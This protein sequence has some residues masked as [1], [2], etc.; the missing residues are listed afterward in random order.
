[1]WMT[2]N[3]LNKKNSILLLTV[4]IFLVLVVF[5]VVSLNF[6]GFYRLNT[7]DLLIF[8]FF[9]SI[10][11]ILLLVSS[12]ILASLLI[13]VIFNKELFKQ[14]FIVTKKYNNPIAILL[15]T[16]DDWIDAVGK[17]CL[18][19]LR[20]NDHLFIC[21]DS[22][23][24]QYKANIDKFYSQ[25]KRRCSVIRRNTLKGW[26]GGNLN[27]ALRNI[28][29][30]YQIVLILDHDNLISED[31]LMYIDA[32]FSKYQNLGFVQFRSTFNNLIRS[33]FSE[34]LKYNVDAVWTLLSIRKITGFRFNVGHLVAFNRNA[35]LDSSLTVAL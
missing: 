11:T 35:I 17:N 25:N 26:K 13:F 18:K 8:I 23:S 7:L 1:M 31:I 3:L 2:L 6:S 32:L 14:T 15:C 33:D 5:L 22:Q 10:L 21:D 4:T 24:N 34:D 28:P 19:S 9:V 12:H 30:N 29:L 20:R 27:N 16:R